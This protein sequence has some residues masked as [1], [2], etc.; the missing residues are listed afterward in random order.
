MN[1]SLMR[2]GVSMAL[3]LVMGLSVLPVSALAASEDGLC[4]H[5]PVHTENC[6]FEEMGICGH[7][8][9]NDNGCITVSCAHTHVET[10]FD[11][12][13]NLNCPHACTD[14]EACYTP[15]TNCLHTEHGGCG[16]T[17]GG[18]CTFAVSGC[19]ECQKEGKLTQIHGTDVTIDGYSFVYTGEEIRPAVT[20]TVG[21]TILTE[22]T[23]Y[24]VAYENNIGVGSASVTVTGMA[25]GGYEG[26]VTIPFAIERDPEMPEF[27]LV[28]IKGTDVIV[29]GTSFPYTGQ[30]IEPAITVTVDG[31]ELTSGQD[32]SVTYENNIEPGTASVTVK[33]IATAS[34][35][36]GYTGEV[37]IEF[38][39]TEAQE[40][41]TPEE[42]KPE[43]DE[44]PEES[45]PEQDETPEESKPE[46]DETPEESKPEEDETPDE[47]EPEQTE[48]VEYKI[49]KGNGKKWYQNSGKTLSF[50]IKGDSDDFTGVS[51]NGKKVDSKYYTIKNDTTVTLKESYLNKLTVGKYKITFEF[52][53]GE[54]NGTFSVSD[55]YD[56]T[57]PTTGDSI[58]LVASVML[59][60]LAALGGCAYVYRKRF[61]K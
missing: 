40:E 30:P 49:T 21:G 7:I 51:V 3:S 23:H 18:E 52:V 25:Q 19:E 32:Y 20:V 8:C 6:G 42:S 26:I 46:Q 28:E 31:K 44:I 39:I 47:S 27:T 58:G 45:K 60:S 55:Q 4:K 43:E 37:T 11:T 33:G 54:A 15:I 34:E 56:E 41:E 10:C 36:L 13:G 61:S 5:H 35:T 29:D 2:R 1:K 22:G 16:H 38:T 53:D 50:T 48:P 59:V 12:E 14:N 17:E 57:N 24:T 9:S